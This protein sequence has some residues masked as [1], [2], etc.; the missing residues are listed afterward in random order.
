MGEKEREKYVRMSQAGMSQ[1]ERQDF[2]KFL[3][4]GNENLEENK[5]MIIRPWTTC[6]ITYLNMLQVLGDSVSRIDFSK[7][8]R[9]VI[10]YDPEQ[11]RVAIHHYS[12][13]K[14]VSGQF[15]TEKE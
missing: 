5:D 9:T 1:E 12:T 2:E 4:C 7:P 13:D 14:S 8:F 6:F 11:V 3:R 10:D 15:Q